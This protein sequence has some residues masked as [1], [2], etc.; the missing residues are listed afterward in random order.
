MFQSKVVQLPIQYILVKIIHS[1][2]E[3]NFFLYGIAQALQ[4][5]NSH[6]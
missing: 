4:I 3:V 5:H 1:T 6:A 2:L